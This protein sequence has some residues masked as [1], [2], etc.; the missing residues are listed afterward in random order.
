[1]FGGSV[2]TGS[3]MLTR[4]VK[5]S[6]SFSH[7]TCTGRYFSKNTQAAATSFGIIMFLPCVGSQEADGY[8]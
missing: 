1:M 4:K 6:K 3:M 7:R 5:S 2:R 8:L